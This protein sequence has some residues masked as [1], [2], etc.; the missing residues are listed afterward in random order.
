[1]KNW[2]YAACLLTVAFTACKAEERKEHK[3]EAMKEKQNE[4]MKE[5]KE[6]GK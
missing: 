6:A 2:I 3:A 1:M 4:Q 5:G